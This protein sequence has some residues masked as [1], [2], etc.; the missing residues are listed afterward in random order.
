[1]S[2]EMPAAEVH[3]L[4]GTLR[5]AAAD[6]EEIA[7]RLDRVGNVGEALQPG[8]EAFLD[9]H[10]TAGRALAGELAWLGATVAAVADSW[11]ALDRALLASRGRA[12]AE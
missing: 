7:P 4:A 12:G 11:L 9:S 8:V 6:A 5:G 2:I 3:A 10:R 1:M